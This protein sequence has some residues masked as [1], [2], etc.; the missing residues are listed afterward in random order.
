[1]VTKN[2]QYI[3]KDF[4][5]LKSKLINFAKTYEKDKDKGPA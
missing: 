5:S 1:M 4:D 3:N 2:I